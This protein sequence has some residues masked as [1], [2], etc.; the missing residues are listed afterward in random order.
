MSCKL[1]FLCQK[2][3]KSSSIVCHHRH[4]DTPPRAAYSRSPA[5]TSK[6]NFYPLR[7]REH[8]TSQLPPHS[9]SLCCREWR[10][11]CRGD[12]GEDAPV[13][14]GAGAGGAGQTPTRLGSLSTRD[15]PTGKL[16]SL[17]L[18][19]AAVRMPPRAAAARSVA[20]TRRSARIPRCCARQGS[21]RGWARRWRRWVLRPPPARPGL[22]SSRRARH[23][24]GSASSSSRAA[25]SLRRRRRRAWTP[26]LQHCCRRRGRTRRG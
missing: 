2:L 15:L 16:G 1:A 22:R 25:A 23:L 14:P 19:G 7:L 9:R 4:T 17:R 5:V 12:M 3:V 26:P 20:L 11:A 21:L 6:L 10:D 8:S 24:S 18:G 13:A